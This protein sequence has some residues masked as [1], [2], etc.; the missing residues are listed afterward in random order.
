ML[1]ARISSSTLSAWTRISLVSS[2]SSMPGGLSSKNSQSGPKSPANRSF[3]GRSPARSNRPVLQY[4][5]KNVQGSDQNLFHCNHLRVLN[6]QIE[7]R[8]A[9][10][11]Q[12]VYSAILASIL[13]DMF[14]VVVLWC[15]PQHGRVQAVASEAPR[16]GCS[17]FDFSVADLRDGGLLARADSDEVEAIVRK[18]RAKNYGLRTLVHEVVQSKLFRHK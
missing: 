17:R 5:P 3:Y 6:R 12:V 15:G 13:L 18:V 14:I 4:F 10:V 8:R 16:S 2:S 11:P 1:P 7:M 9:G